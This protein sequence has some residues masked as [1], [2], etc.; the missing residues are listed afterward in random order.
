[1]PNIKN[2]ADNTKLAD[3]V[4]Q[5]TQT[6]L[7]ASMMQEADV[8]TFPRS[9]YKKNLLKSQLSTDLRCHSCLYFV[10]W[11]THLQGHRQGPYLLE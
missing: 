3:I 11:A 5:S 8:T 10:D 6:I 7:N 9:E 4:S 2:G 1:M